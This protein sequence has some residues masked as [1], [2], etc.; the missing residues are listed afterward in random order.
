MKVIA[1]IHTIVINC[2]SR[3]ISEKQAL[4]LIREIL[5]DEKA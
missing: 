1:A 4:E 3:K 5:R 2:L